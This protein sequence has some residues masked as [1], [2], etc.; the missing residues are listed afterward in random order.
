MDIQSILTLIDAVSKADIMN[1]EIEKENF[2]LKMDKLTS[3]IETSDP[4]QSVPASSV[5]PQTTEHRMDEKKGIVVFDN[6]EQGNM[7]EVKS[8]IVGTFYSAA[9]PDQGDY[10]KIGDKVSVGQTLCIVEAM[11]L[12]NEIDSEYNGEV[13]EILVKNEQMVEF[14]QPLFKIKIQE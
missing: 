8:P 3:R 1:F 6:T 4:V 2:K 13:V 11:K 5:I 7:K 10:V 9:G 12:M 14:G